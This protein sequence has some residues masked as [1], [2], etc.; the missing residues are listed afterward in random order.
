M[1]AYHPWDCH[2]GKNP[3]SNNATGFSALPGGS[4]GS[5][6]FG[7]IGSSTNFWTSTETQPNKARR[8]Q[9]DMEW[10]LWETDK[11]NGF[12]IRCLKE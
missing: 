2:P 9:L 10:S 6:G 4:F 11:Y 5:S 7:G 8:I 1:W 3:A 12:S